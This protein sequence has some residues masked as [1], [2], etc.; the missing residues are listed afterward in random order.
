MIRRPPRS[1]LFPYTTLFRSACAP[2]FSCSISNCRGIS[3]ERRPTGINEI[4]RDG[5]A[6]LTRTALSSRRRTRTR[7]ADAEPATDIRTLFSDERV[8]ELDVFTGGRAD[9]GSLGLR[10]HAEEFRHGH[11]REDTDDDDHHHQ[12]NEGKTLLFHTDLLVVVSSFK[13]DCPY[14]NQDKHFLHEMQ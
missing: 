13:G 1:T 14:T 9:F 5:F 10:D 2:S 11:G 12:F 3:R 6:G 8:L 4:G 7:I